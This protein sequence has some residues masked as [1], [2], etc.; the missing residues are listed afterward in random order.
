MHQARSLLSTVV[1]SLLSHWLPVT[2]ALAE[3][4]VLGADPWCPMICA[5]L[6]GQPGFMV[7]A[8]QMAL[9]PH[10]YEVEYRNLPWSRALI[11][12]ESG[13]IDGLF[14]ANQKRERI[15][16]LPEHAY[17]WSVMGYAQHRRREQIK[18]LSGPSLVGLNFQLIQDYDYAG[19]TPL[20]PWLSAHPDR[21]S[22]NRGSD[23]LPRMLG[24]IM[25]GRGD[26]TLDNLAVLQYSLKQLNLQDSFHTAPVSEPYKTYIGISRRHPKAR[27]IADLLSREMQAMREDGRLKRLLIKYGVTARLY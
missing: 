12:A 2:P 6:P 21:V 11:E 24:M 15:V 20:G 26:I 9:A 14:A 10:G 3:Q 5:E 13:R 18:D 17:F 22:Y 7:E 23:P 19:T 1:F 27:L 16:I 8:A 4:I 25:L